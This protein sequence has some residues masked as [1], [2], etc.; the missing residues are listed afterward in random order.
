MTFGPGDRVLLEAV[1][2]DVDLDAGIGRAVGA[3]DLDATRRELAAS[4]CRD[5]DLLFG[6][7]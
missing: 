2:P 1:A 4:A 7:C 6:I 3:R 5:F